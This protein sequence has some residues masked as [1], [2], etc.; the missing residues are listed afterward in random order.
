MAH[1]HSVTDHPTQ[2]IGIAS[3]AALIG[4]VIALLITPKRGSET[5]NE[6]R[7]RAMMLRQ[8]MNTAGH[9]INNNASDNLHMVT[10][11]FGQTVN[12]AEKRVKG[13][14]NKISNDANETIKELRQNAKSSSKNIQDETDH[15]R[16]HGER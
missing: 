7:S 14:I 6:I 1:R 4:A 15:I 3:F 2:I 12:N 16:K 10:D 8:K 9:Q 13:T 11:Q 5:R